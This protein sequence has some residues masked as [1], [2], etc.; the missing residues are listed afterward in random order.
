MTTTATKRKLEKEVKRLERRFGHRSAV[1]GSE[2]IPLDVI[3][4][5]SLALDYAL[6]TGGWPRG[7]PVEI[8]GGNDIGKSSA[9]G[10]AALRNAQAQGLLCGIV[11]IEPGVDSG[12][13]EL[14]G[15]NLDE[16]LIVRPDTGEEAFSM[17]NE[18][19]SNDIIDCVLF[20]SVGALL[21]ETEVGADAK[22]NVGGAGSL[23]TWGIKNI[24]MPTFKN[25]KSVIFLNQQRADMH[26]R[27]PGR[28]KPYG[29]EAMRHL[30]AQRVNLRQ[31]GPSYRKK[32]VGDDKEIDIGR[33]LV[34]TVERNKLNQGSRQRAEFDYYFKE[35]DE[36]PLGIDVGQDI[37]NTAI[38]TRVVEGTGY[39]HHSTFPGK[40]NQIQGKEAVANFLLSHP[41]AF[42]TVRQEVLGKMLEVIGGGQNVAPTEE[43][44]EKVEEVDG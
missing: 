11:A 41:D 4:T 22:P 32:F 33:K 20:D 29:A 35:T 23:V 2:R 36:H 43:D 24:L 10:S 39:Y 12:W 15:V 27:I 14:H 17:L 44:V 5:G 38:R 34:A 31:T 30:C 13:L 6:G 9:L 21:R 16:L 37:V 25:N 1:L 3:P 28:M 18:W 7:H 40:N 8:W 26:S 42:E 19:V